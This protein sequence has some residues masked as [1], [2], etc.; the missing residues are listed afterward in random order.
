MLKKQTVWLLT[1]LS[2]MVVLSVYYILSPKTDEVAFIDDGNEQN[3][4]EVS[5]DVEG[6]EDMDVEDMTG[7]DDDDTFARIRLD[8][9]DKRSEEKSRLNDVVASSSASPDEKNEALEKV[10]SLEERSS[11]ESILEE[12]ILAESD[13]DDVLVRSNEDKVFVHVQTSDLSDEEVVNIMQMVNDEYGEDKPVVVN[14][15]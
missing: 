1:M 14:T 9:E 2:L 6:N 4:E 12:S 5:E 13:Y 8:V 10:D 15:Q 3:N 11:S 7:E